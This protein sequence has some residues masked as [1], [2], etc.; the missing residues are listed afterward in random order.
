MKELLY[1]VAWLLILP[2]GAMLFCLALGAVML[3]FGLMTSIRNTEND[4]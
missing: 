1:D 4:T 3:L 2:V